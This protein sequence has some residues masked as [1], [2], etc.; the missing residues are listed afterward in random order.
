GNLPRGPVGDWCRGGTSIRGFYGEHRARREFINAL[1]D[2]MGSRD[3]VMAH[4]EHQGVAIDL[5]LEIR[6]D[7]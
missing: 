3:V 6:M 5:A 2:G 1:V 7:T 4:E